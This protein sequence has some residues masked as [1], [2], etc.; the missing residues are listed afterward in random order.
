MQLP[1]ETFV[2]NAYYRIN[3]CFIFLS[4]LLSICEFKKYIFAIQYPITINN[5]VCMCVCVCRYK[6]AQIEVNKPWLSV[7][8]YWAVHHESWITKVA[9]KLTIKLELASMPIK[10]WLYGYQMSDIVCFSSSYTMITVIIDWIG[11]YSMVGLNGTRNCKLT[12]ERK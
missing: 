5:S 2:R 3:D 6:Y 10:H 9:Y 11:F 8:N 4:L 7:M 12:R 1:T